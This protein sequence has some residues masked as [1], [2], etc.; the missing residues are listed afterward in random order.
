[1]LLTNEQINALRKALQTEKFTATAEYYSY[2]SGFMAGMKT[3]FIL[4]LSAMHDQLRAHSRSGEDRENIALKLSIRD[5]INLYNTFE[6]LK[7][8]NA[9]I[10]YLFESRED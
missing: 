2:I 6:N 5:A 9:E 8:D 4:T 10:A 1:M 7:N 3:A